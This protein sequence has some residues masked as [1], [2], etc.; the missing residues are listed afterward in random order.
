MRNAVYCCNRCNG[1]KKDKL[2]TSWLNELP[3]PFREHSRALYIFKH[4]H[5]PETFE[6]GSIEFRSEGIPMFLELDEK[7][8]KRELRGM[9]PLV[10][11][12]PAGYLLDVLQPHP[13]PVSI[14]SM[15]YRVT[16][17]RND[18]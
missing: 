15:I 18:N 11:G 13:G 16:L 6:V 9:L 7:Q 14:E 17:E 12:P 8:F 3:Q 10:D 4:E 2:F 1:I 5:Q